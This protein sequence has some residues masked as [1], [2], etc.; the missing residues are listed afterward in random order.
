MRPRLR[1]R[2]GDLLRLFHAR[3]VGSEAL[4]KLHK[5]RRIGRAVRS[6]A[7]AHQGAAEPAAQARMRITF[8]IEKLLD[9]THHAEILIIKYTY[10]NRQLLAH[11]R[12]QLLHIHLKAPVAGDQHDVLLRP[13]QLR[14]DRGRE[15]EAHRSEAPGGDE[16]AVRSELAELDRPHLVLSDIGHQKAGRELPVYL[17]EDHLRRHP[18][19]PSLAQRIFLLPFLDPFLPGHRIHLLGPFQELFQRGSRIRDHRHIH[20]HIP[21]NGGRIHIDMHNGRLRRKFRKVPGNPVVKAGADGKQ[22]VAFHH[23]HIRRVF[24]MHS[25][26]SDIQA[27]IGRKRSLSH[28]RGHHRDPHR[29]HKLPEELVRTGDVHP[30]ARQDQR[31]LCA[32]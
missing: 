26:A 22:H 17:F 6:R 2:P 28:D 10:N 7:L 32:L 1:Q 20:L 30:A 19:I 31:A 15:A 23:G 11:S 29:L 25:A 27:V 12:C 3:S 13:A 5:V 24:S 18:A 9:L 4:R 16:P 21:G 14:S 8:S